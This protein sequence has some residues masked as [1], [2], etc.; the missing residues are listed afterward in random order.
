MNRNSGRSEFC[1]GGKKK[2]DDGKKRKTAE[3]GKD[4]VQNG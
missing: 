4:K 2:N 1:R 3:E